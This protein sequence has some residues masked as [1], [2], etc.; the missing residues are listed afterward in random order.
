MLFS[1]S[2]PK[3]QGLSSSEYTAIG[4]SSVL[5]ALIYIASVS[6]Y[7]H[8]RKTRRKDNEEHSVEVGNCTVDVQEA[9]GLVKCNPLL[10]V[11]RHFE[12]DTNS[13]VSEADLVDKLLL[14]SESESEIE[15]VNVSILLLLCDA[16]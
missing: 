9:P 3:P 7:L 5:L 14:Q 6:L 10:S 1:T 2:P 8:S 16:I 15:S 11:S 4:V 12:S 13:A